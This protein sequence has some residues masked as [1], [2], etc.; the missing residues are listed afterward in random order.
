MLRSWVSL[1]YL[2]VL[3]GATVKSLVTVKYLCTVYRVSMFQCV[4]THS[5][6]HLVLFSEES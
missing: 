4:T 6:G 2:L 1:S 5:L 3:S